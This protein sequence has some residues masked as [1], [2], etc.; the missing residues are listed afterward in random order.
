MFIDNRNQMTVSSFRSEMSHPIWRD[1]Y[2]APKR[3][4]GDHQ[5]LRQSVPDLRFSSMA[6]MLSLVIVGVNFRK[7]EEREQG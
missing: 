3:L 6:F 1:L 2:Y 7:R 4:S 5:Q